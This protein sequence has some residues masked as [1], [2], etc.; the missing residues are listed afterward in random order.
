MQYEYKTKVLK[1]KGVFITKFNMD[2]L[3]EELEQHGKEGWELVS[4]FATDL[5]NNGKKEVVLIFKRAMD[6]FV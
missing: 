5:D 4:S 2:L 1:E 3:N 6:E